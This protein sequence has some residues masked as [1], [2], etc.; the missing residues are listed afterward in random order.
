MATNYQRGYQ[1]E[2]RAKSLLEENGYFWV[3]RSPASKGRFDVTAVGRDT[4]LLQLKRTKRKP[5]PSLYKEEMEELEKWCQSQT[6]PPHI[7]I[8]WWCWWDSH[9]WH[10][11]KYD[12]ATQKFVK[13][14]E[15]GKKKDLVN[16]L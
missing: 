1:L 13:V 8:E 2:H 9:G 16:I 6:L 14:L 10:I 12:R 7:S 3:M 15:D 11:W 5:V 4:K